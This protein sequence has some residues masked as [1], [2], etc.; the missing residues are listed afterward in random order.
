MKIGFQI[1][2]FKGVTLIELLVVLTIIAILARV[3][4][5]SYQAYVVKGSRAAVQ[6]ELLQLANLQEK[7]YLNSSKYSTSLGNAY[8]GT[9]ASTN[10]LGSSET[11]KDG[12]YTLS[13]STPTDQSFTL[14]PTPVPEKSQANDGSLSISQSG[15]K[16]WGTSHW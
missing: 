15:Q 3:A 9:D 10:G 8:N 14:T 6:V 16:I 12:R 4:M 13:L 1:K 11:S 2:R 5:P 7:I